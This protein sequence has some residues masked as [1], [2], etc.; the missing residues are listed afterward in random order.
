ME[1]SMRSPISYTALGVALVAG[2]AVAHAQT[3]D[4]VI[5]PQP[6]AVVTV[7]AP[8]ATVQTVRTVQTVTTPRRRIVHRDRVTT[9][10]TT[11]TERVLPATPAVA[12]IAQPTYMDVVDV[13]PRLYDVVTPAPDAL[14]P[15]AGPMTQPFVPGAAIATQTVLPTYRY[16]YEPNRILVIDP[17]T[18][19]AVQ[20][21]PR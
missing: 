5:A 2:T 10:R 8:V 12:A 15:V 4:A 14:P 19:I 13:P 16:V 3:V 1:L 11:V 17:Y 18:N 20:A 21:I 6:A 9:T 7:P